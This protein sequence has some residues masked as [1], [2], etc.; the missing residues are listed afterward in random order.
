[1]VDERN[2]SLNTCESYAYAFKLL[3]EFTADQFKTPPSKLCFEQIDA[4]LVVEFL[5]YLESR[6]GNGAVSTAERMCTSAAEQ[7]C[8]IRTAA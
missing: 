1:L 2:A 8:P 4:P 3:F 6:R 7:K 5:N